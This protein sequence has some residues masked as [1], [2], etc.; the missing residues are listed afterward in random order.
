[1][2]DIKPMGIIEKV[3]V[4]AGLTMAFIV[5]WAFITA[6]LMSSAPLVWFALTGKLP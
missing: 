6:F 3:F 2:I 4:G 1:M 5:V